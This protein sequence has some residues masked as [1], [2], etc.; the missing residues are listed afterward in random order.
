M[1]LYD[2]YDYAEI[3]DKLLIPETREEK[4]EDLRMNNKYTYVVK[5]ITSGE[6]VES[7]IYPI[8]KC[9]S[10]VPRRKEKNESRETQKNLNNKNSRKKVT[11]LLN[12]NFTKDD[13]S[14]SLTYDDKNLPTLDEARRDIQNYIKRLKRYRKKNGLEDLKYLYV[15]EFEDKKSKK[16]RVHHHIVINNMDR[17]VAEDLWGKGWANADRLKPNDFG[18]EGISRYIT[19]NLNSSRRWSGSRNLK[20]PKVR[21]SRTRLTR[22]KVENLAKNQND[23]KEIFERVYPN[24]IYKDSKT[25]FSDIASG[26]Y[27][28]VILRKKEV[29]KE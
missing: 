21:K 20:Q 17:N 8:W 1:R 23:F 9:R 18:L 7:E 22:R 29:K 11:R 6:M 4:I 10:D 5:T 24:C 16:T 28:Y 2:D 27:L 3:Y 26:Y 25:M 14:I 13:L 19:K 15:I 12:T